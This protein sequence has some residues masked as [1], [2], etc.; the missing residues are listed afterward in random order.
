MI[1]SSNF[2]SSLVIRS[3]LVINSKGK[4]LFKSKNEF[5]IMIK[6]PKKIA[7]AMFILVTVLFAISFS[8]FNWNIFNTNSDI[9]SIYKEVREPLMF[10]V[11]TTFFLHYYVQIL[12]GEKNPE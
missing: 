11:L 1:K 10:L 5:N 9:E 12:K 6:L 3:S 8:N 2:G 4:V 7:F